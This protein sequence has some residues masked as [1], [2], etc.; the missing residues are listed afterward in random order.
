MKGDSDREVAIFTQALKVPRQKRDALLDR[1]CNGDNNLHQKVET[2]LRAHDRVGSFLN[3]PAIPETL[4]SMLREI[5]AASADA[6]RRG[7]KKTGRRF[8]PRPK[9]RKRKI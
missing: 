9:N 2:L 4:V 6:D 8:Q 5:S 7:H 1:M 3:E